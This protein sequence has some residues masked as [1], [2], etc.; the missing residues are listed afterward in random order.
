MLDKIIIFFEDL[1]KKQVGLICLVN[2]LNNELV[3]T[4]VEKGFKVSKLQDFNMMAVLEKWNKSYELMEQEERT[5]RDS[6]GGSKH[7]MAMLKNFN[8]R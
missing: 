1:Q 8:G 4:S 2:K 6:Q 5:I 3:P 7:T